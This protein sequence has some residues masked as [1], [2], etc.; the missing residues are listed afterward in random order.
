MAHF[1]A[2]S[3]WDD[4]TFDP[5]DFP[6]WWTEEPGEPEGLQ[7]VGG[8]ADRLLAK[9]LPIGRAT[10][11]VEE[12]ATIVGLGRTGA[13]EAVRRKDIPSRRVNGRIVIPVPELIRWL[14]A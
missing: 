11:T 9:V 14:G 12:M 4:P 2:R 5:D 3:P 7:P 10:V 1:P 13:Y 6:S 8:P